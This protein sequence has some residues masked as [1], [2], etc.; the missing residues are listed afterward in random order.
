M[1]P[2]PKTEAERQQL[3]TLILD[4]AREL[5]A[6]R[7]VDAVTMREIAK[8]IG[9]S[10]TAIYLHFN[11][12]DS[13]IRELCDTDFLALASNLNQ[14]LAIEHPVERMVALGQSYAE[15]ALTH[16]NHY[17]IMFMSQ[18]PSCSPED[19]KVP[20]GSA[21]HDAYAQLKLVVQDVYAQGLFREDL[22]DADLIAQ[23]IWA[24]IHGVCSLEIAMSNDAW[25]NWSDIQ[26]RLNSMQQMM[27][28]GLIK[29]QKH[30]G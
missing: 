19:S 3:R 13:L 12:K 23:T 30:G 24:G 21:E 14:I 28:H 25:V 1:P 5:F 17:R 2:K 26:A 22:Q 8:K 4:A 11:D 10:S 15:F 29:V 20:Q 16:P 7:G 9:Y 18:R 6:T 27:L